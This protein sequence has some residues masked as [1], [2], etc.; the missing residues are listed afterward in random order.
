MQQN[1][2]TE[3][4]HKVTHAH[5][6][7]YLATQVPRQCNAIFLKLTVALIGKDLPAGFM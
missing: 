3:C 6:V 1:L 5:S 2:D 4:V 7:L